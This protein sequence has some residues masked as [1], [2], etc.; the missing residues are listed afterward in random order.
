MD[1]CRQPVEELIRAP[2]GEQGGAG[3]HGNDK[4]QLCTGTPPGGGA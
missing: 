1:A 4:D 2:N 3:D